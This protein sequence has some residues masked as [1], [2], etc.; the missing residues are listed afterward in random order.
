MKSAESFQMFVGGKMRVEVQEIWRNITLFLRVNCL[1]PHNSCIGL[2]P[3]MWCNYALMENFKVK[4][5]NGFL[6]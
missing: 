1:P 3:S 5:Q 2:K 6:K 4:A